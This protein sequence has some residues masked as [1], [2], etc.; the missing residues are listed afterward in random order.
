M[1]F[2]TIEDGLSC[3]FCKDKILSG[4]GFRFGKV[5]R[6]KYRVGDELVWDG[7]DCR[8]PSRP[9]A[10]VIK[11]IGYF[12]C[13][14]FKCDSWSDCFP[15]VQQALITIENNRIASVEH[16]TGPLPEDEQFPILEPADLG[17]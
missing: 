3:P 14:N 1:S 2:N 8:P 9:S 4:I 11:I 16:Y 10:P 12:N 5:A 17:S 13:D 7:P 6:L 15:E